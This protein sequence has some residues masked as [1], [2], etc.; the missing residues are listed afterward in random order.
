MMDKILRISL[1]LF[2]SLDKQFQCCLHYHFDF[3]IASQAL[4]KK[5]ILML[6]FMMKYGYQLWFFLKPED[7][8]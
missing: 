2:L 5:Q 3:P 8:S 1:L 4:F 7:Y 6:I